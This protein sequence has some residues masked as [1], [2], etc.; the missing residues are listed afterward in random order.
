VWGPT[1]SNSLFPLSHLYQTREVLYFSSTSLSSTSLSPFS[2]LPNRSWE[3]WWNFVGLLNYVE[4]MFWFQVL[5]NF[6]CLLMYICLQT[7][8]GTSL[9]IWEIKIWVFGWKRVGTRN[10]FY[11]ID[12]SSLKWTASERQAKCHQCLVP[13]FR[14]SEQ[15]F[16]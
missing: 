8:F 15:V 3:F 12:D 10:I 16:A 11:I 7:T 1:G 4:L 2:L 5:C 13:K 6:E 9:D 14:L